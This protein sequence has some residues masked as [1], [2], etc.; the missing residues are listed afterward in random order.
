MDLDSMDLKSDSDYEFT[1]NLKSATP[2][3]LMTFDEMG[4]PSTCGGYS[5]ASLA[6]PKDFFP[7]EGEH[8]GCVGEPK[9]VIPHCPSSEAADQAGGHA[10]TFYELSEHRI[11]KR[12]FNFDA[13]GLDCGG[14]SV[15]RKDIHASQVEYHAIME[16]WCIQRLSQ[17][18]NESQLQDY[19]LAPI[20]SGPDAFG[21]DIFGICRMGEGEHAGI[22]LVMENVLAHY[23]QPCQIDL[24]LGKTTIEPE[25]G[26]LRK[27]VLH[28][29]IDRLTETKS[30]GVRQEG[31][32][33]WSPFDE[34]VHK[35]NRGVARFSE[36]MDES[37]EQFFGEPG[38]LWDEP[39]GRF[40][41]DRAALLA[42]WWGRV[43]A[44]EFRA[45]GLSALVA[46]E[47]HPSGEGFELADF[48]LRSAL[49]AESS[50]GLRAAVRSHP[51]GTIF[52]QVSMG[53]SSEAEASGL[54]TKVF[55]ASSEEWSGTVFRL[56]RSAGA[57]AVAFEV[58]SGEASSKRFIG[59]A[60]VRSDALTEGRHCVEIAACNDCGDEMP[61]FCFTMRLTGRIGD[62]VTAEPSLTLID[63]A[64][65]YSSS[66]R[67]EW[68][69]EDG[70]HE[71]LESL[72]GLFHDAHTMA[73][74][75]Y[76]QAQYL[77][78]TTAHEVTSVDGDISPKQCVGGI[79]P[80]GWTGAL[81]L[82]WFTLDEC[83]TL[84]ASNGKPS[85]MWRNGDDHAGRCR[86]CES[87]SVAEADL[88]QTGR[89]SSSRWHA[90][91]L[92]Q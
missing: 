8:S 34:S 71:G 62:N 2:W 88:D 69:Q 59:R 39:L 13:V 23:H 44:H 70:V 24:K 31:Y 79:N 61:E 76:H 51:E 26:S 9:S 4:C 43:G 32:R 12:A 35:F 56:G 75:V 3:R 91:R 55:V 42:E 63:Y 68:D 17:H 47:C 74:H 27:R 25:T 73:D 87:L 58:Y 81:G 67:P 60:L 15:R 37:L 77:A 86:I 52:P 14:H 45:V 6:G 84:A 10:G 85:F 82:G 21:A 57:Q 72:A 50:E 38:H 29:V 78:N 80:A 28:S 36:R 89:R 83:H 7:M 11:G 33:I 64:H 30:L 53:Y 18:G 92:A 65:F 54:G 66:D 41:E 40:F 46:Y 22:F 1:T 20:A 90:F 49:D 19:P 5:V 16:M 48:E